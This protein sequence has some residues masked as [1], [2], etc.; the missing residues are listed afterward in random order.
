MAKK[1]SSIKKLYEEIC[2]LDN[3]RIAEIK[4]GIQD[5]TISYTF[6]NRLFVMVPS[7]HTKRDQAFRDFVSDLFD[8]VKPE[9]VLLEQ[10]MDI[11]RRSIDSRMNRNQASYNDDI[12]WPFYLAKMHSIK[13]GFS[14]APLRDLVNFYLKMDDGIELFLF[15]Y[16]T[17]AYNANRVLKLSATDAYE[18]SKNNIISDF[19]YN[20]RPLY[21]YRNLL[22]SLQRKYKLGSISKCIDFSMQGLVNK[23]IAKEPI[24]KLLAKE[25]NLHTPYPFYKKY[26]INKI[27][28]Y[29][30]SFR[31]LYMADNFIKSLRIYKRVISI[32]GVGHAIEL[33]QHMFNM[34]ENNFSKC[35][36]HRVRI[37]RKC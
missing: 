16:I 34:I 21:Q 15:F 12:E 20:Q 22:D 26:K 35:Q 24:I 36:M 29:V 37:L 23:Y 1:M 14:D 2:S 19:V 5:N 30:E 3:E 8:R 7:M 6:S 17:A 11:S 31:N 33:R 18:L 13:I 4:K 28:T 10:P 32:N 9:M 27:N 25:V